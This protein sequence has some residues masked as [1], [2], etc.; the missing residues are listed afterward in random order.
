TSVMDEFLMRGNGLD[1]SVTDLTDRRA[2]IAVQGPL[3]AD[4]V[5]S[6]CERGSTDVMTL[7][8]YRFANVVLVGGIHAVVSRTGYTGE[9]GFELY[10]DADDAVAVWR[11]ALALG[12]PAGVV[13]CGLA[14][15]DS[16]RL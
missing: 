16:L 15:R 8:Y 3:S 1:A 5:R 14:A 6:M 13:P 9:D 7:K 12:E 11:L 10:V 2:L 4:I